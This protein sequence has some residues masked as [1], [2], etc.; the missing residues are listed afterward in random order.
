MQWC[1]TCK[2]FVGALVVFQR[3]W[4][5]VVQT[6]GM[7]ESKRPK[8][9]SDDLW[10]GRHCMQEH[11]LCMGCYDAHIAFNHAILPVSTDATKRVMLTSNIKVL[12]KISGGEN[13]II[14]MNMFDSGI[15]MCSVGF[16]SF[17]G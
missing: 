5:H 4:F 17:L 8:F 12:G 2:K 16:I 11:C 15:K 10:S 6:N 13:T 1:F 7:Y 3:Y 9:G 14:G